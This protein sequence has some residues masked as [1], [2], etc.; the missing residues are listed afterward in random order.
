MGSDL[1]HNIRQKAS[2]R[3]IGLSILRVA[4]AAIVLRNVIFFWPMSP[5]LFGPH[6]IVPYD[7]YLQSLRVY[8]LVLI[9]YPFQVPGA[10]RILLA[11]TFVCSFCF[12]LGILK[13][14]SGVGLILTLMILR[15]RNGFIL[16]GS[17]NVIQVI[18]PFLVFAD[19]YKYFTYSLPQPRWYRRLCIYARRSTIIQTIKYFSCLGVMLQICYVY[20]FTA[21]AKLQGRLW[22]NGTAIYYTMRVDEFRATNWNIPLTSN[23][24]FVVLGTYFTLLI[25]LSFPFLVWF[26]QTKYF[27]LLGGVALHVG[28]WIFMRIDNF[29]WIMIASYAVF[30]T[31]ADYGIIKQYLDN[32][33]RRIQS[34][35]IA[36]KAYD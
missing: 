21:L 6:A 33:Y 17:D 32:W 4:T 5:E 30:V 22:Q 16:D 7:V 15:M 14:I 29:S 18:L 8:D 3:A 31:N 26:Y 27:I 1:C 11:I 25:E 19:S 36:A 2:S 20:F 28:I 9:S 35:R 13:R 23:H 10:A 12:L 34:G 24:Y